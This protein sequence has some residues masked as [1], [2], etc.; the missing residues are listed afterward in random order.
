VDFGDGSPIETFMA[1]DLSEPNTLAVNHK[2][3]EYGF[4]KGYV[5]IMDAYGRKAVTPFNVQ[6]TYLNLLPIIQT[7][8]GVIP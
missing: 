7:F 4:Y 6:V 1:S 5:E 8:P 2:Y 3:P